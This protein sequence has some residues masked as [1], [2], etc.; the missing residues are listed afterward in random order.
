MARNSVTSSTYG[1]SVVIING[2]KM[3]TSEYKKL[4]KAKGK[5]KAAPKKKAKKEASEIQLD[6]IDIKTMVKGVRL[7]KSL[8]AYH[9]NGYRQ[10]GT[11]HKTIVGLNG[12]RQPFS[13]Y[14]AKYWEIKSLMTEIEKIG[15]KSEKAVYQ[16]M[17]KLGYL[18]DD[19]IEIIKELSKGISSNNICQAFANEKAIYEN[20]KR[21]GLKELMSRVSRTLVDMQCIVNKCTGYSVKGIDPFEYS[22]KAFNGMMSCWCKNER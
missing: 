9:T 5:I 8:K 14:N 19:M 17:E 20:D 6:T 21:L 3:T 2:V 22:T 11:I 15:G 16:Y 13:K 7:L 12:I 4:L 1:E 10:W 18:I